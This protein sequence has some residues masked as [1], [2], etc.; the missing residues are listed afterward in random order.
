[1]GITTLRTLKQVKIL[2]PNHKLF[3]SQESNIEKLFGVATLPPSFPPSGTQAFYFINRENGGLLC[4]QLYLN[5][6][7][8]H[9]FY[10]HCNTCIATGTEKVI[11]NIHAPILV[12][13]EHPHALK[14]MDR[15]RRPRTVGLLAKQC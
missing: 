9:N 1:M 14:V 8:T 4:T 6:F 3:I 11:E 10:C 15:A 13:C 2:W 7:K 5:S 12:I